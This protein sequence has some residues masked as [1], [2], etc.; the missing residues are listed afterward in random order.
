MWIDLYARQVA[1]V[2]AP[3]KI[4][5]GVGGVAGVAVVLPAGPMTPIS[6]RP[7]P[8]LRARPSSCAVRG[9]IRPPTAHNNVPMPL[10]AAESP[11]ISISWLWNADRP[12]TSSA[13]P[14]ARAP[15][16]TRTP[17]SRPAAG[18][19]VDG[20]VGRHGED[21]A[22]TARLD[23]LPSAAPSRINPTTRRSIHSQDVTA[24]RVASGPVPPLRLF[25]VLYC[26]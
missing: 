13:P 4:T 10:I 20:S 1:V 5:V 17:A 23:D 3:E 25:L 26:W 11:R 12:E 21:A 24:P 6:T 9:N 7:G 14:A 8:G 2:L 16:A 19:A 18:N 15:G 22:R